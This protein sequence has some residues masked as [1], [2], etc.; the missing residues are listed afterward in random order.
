MS[1][2]RGTKMYVGEE[3]GVLR[4]LENFFRSYLHC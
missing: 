2:I 4:R 1:L 3:A